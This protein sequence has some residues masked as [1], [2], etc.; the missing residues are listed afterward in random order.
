MARYA[1]TWCQMQPALEE[2]LEHVQLDDVLSHLLHGWE[3]HGIDVLL[4]TQ[5]ADNN[6]YYSLDARSVGQLEV[7]SRTEYLKVC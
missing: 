2:A 5:H 1:L 6:G 4:H 7:Q 3:V